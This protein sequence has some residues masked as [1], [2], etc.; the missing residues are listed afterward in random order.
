MVHPIRQI[1]PLLATP[2]HGNQ[3]NQSAI[4][5]V[6]H[7]R[8]Y[9]A[10]W[11]TGTHSNN[12]GSWKC[13]EAGDLGMSKCFHPCHPSWEDSGCAVGRAHH[14]TWLRWQCG[15]SKHAQGLTQEANWAA[16]CTA[17]C[18]QLHC[19]VV[20]VLQ[21]PFHGPCTTATI[22]TLLLVRHW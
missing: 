2:C 16:S 11:S 9:T 10:F 20:G 7:H 21:T 3:K 12:L 5:E 19:R 15:H 17:S 14:S 4:A 18:P 1:G 6:G 22:G 13:Q 8:R